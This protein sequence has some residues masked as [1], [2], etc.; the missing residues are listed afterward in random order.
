MFHSRSQGYYNR[1]EEQ[2]TETLKM[3]KVNFRNNQYFQQS[4]YHFKDLNHKSKTKDQFWL[5]NVAQ[6][7]ENTLFEIELLKKKGLN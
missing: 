2:R 3:I 4:A 1:A 7:V 6:P 5:L